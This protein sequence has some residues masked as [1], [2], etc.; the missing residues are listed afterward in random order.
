MIP[1]KYY[2]YIKKISNN[3]DKVNTFEA[4]TEI[5][6]NIINSFLLSGGDYKIFIQ[7][8][9]IEKAWCQFQSQKIL[10]VNKYLILI[11]YE[12][13]AYFII[14]CEIYNNFKKFIQIFGEKICV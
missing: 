6:A 7:N 11:V 14:R 8:L 4:Y 5:W 10:T 2:N 3:F 1:L 9:S 13:L 12:Y